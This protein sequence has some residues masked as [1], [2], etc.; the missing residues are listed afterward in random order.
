MLQEHSKPIKK[1]FVYFIRPCAN[2]SVYLSQHESVCVVLNI[3]IIDF[4][5]LDADLLKLCL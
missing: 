5:Q 4:N 1:L 3:I 2:E